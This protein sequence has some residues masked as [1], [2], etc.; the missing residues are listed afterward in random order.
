MDCRLPAVHAG[1]WTD[2]KLMYSAASSELELH[3]NHRL[4]RREYAAATP[5]LDCEQPLV[6][7][8]VGAMKL[9]FAGQVRNVRLGNVP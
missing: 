5:L 7:G 9:R 6:L 8:G 3:I 4:V 2:L 1:K